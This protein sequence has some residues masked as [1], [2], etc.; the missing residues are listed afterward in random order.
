LTGKH[1]KT[2]RTLLILDA[3][4]GIDSTGVAVIGHHS[5]VKIAK[6]LGNPYNLLDSKAFDRALAGR[7]CVIIGH[8]RW[9]TQGKVNT[10]NAHPF[11]VGGIVGAHNGTLTNK[12]V[13]PDAKDFDVDS[14]NLIHVMDKIG[15]P[16]AIGMVAGA[17]ALVWYNTELGTINFLRNE[18]RPL[19]FTMTED[20][21]IFW[22]S[23]R[24]MLEV[25]LSRESVKHHEI[26]P[27]EVDTWLSIEI[28]DKDFLGKPHATP[29]KSKVAKPIPFQGQQ[30]HYR[31]G[32]ANEALNQTKTPVAEAAAKK[33]EPDS[34]TALSIIDQK[35]LDSTT[36]SV[37]PFPGPNPYKPAESVFLEVVGVGIDRSNATY[38]V[39][40]D[41]NWPAHNIRL[42]KMPKD[43]IDFMGKH[44]ECN[45]HQYR[46][47]DKAGAYYKVEH[48]SV[49]LVDIKADK[50]EM[51]QDAKGKLITKAEWNHKYGTCAFCTGYVDPET[52]FKFTHEGETLC[53]ICAEDKEVLACT[54]VKN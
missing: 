52:A 20:N 49:F 11:H 29:V 30:T 42:Y 17:W 45:I 10:L 22:A 12:Y 5:D 44:I 21:V 24:W 4:R 46:Y 53:H 14:E 6:S 50:Q 31:K 41:R 32:W 19:Y 43:T 48:S 1:E 51:F 39:C 33:S 9:A 18:E 23:E 15:V 7:N 3:L 2:V 54:N 13:L 28:D 34:T 8:N 47:T 16:E 36:K 27:L 40:R 26:V 38:Y 37:V 25:A 35:V